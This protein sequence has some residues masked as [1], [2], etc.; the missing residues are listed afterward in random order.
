[1]PRP[2]ERIVSLCPSTSESVIALGAGST[3]VGI[4]RF[5]VHPAEQ[6]ERLTKVGGT[7]QPNVERIVALNP[8][9]VL[10]N[11]E[12]NRREDHAALRERGLRVE[13]SFPKGPQEIPAH[14]RWLG[15]LLGRQPAGEDWAG[16]IEAELARP[17][18]GPGFDYVY[19]VWRDPWMA[20]GPDTYIDR[21]LAW[22]GGRNLAGP[23]R[24]PTLEPGR[25]ADP[26]VVLLPD[27]PFP[28]AEKHRGEVQQTFPRSEPRFVSGD[29][30]C[31]HGVRT[32]R[33]LRLARTL[34]EERTRPG[35][36][37]APR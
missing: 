25:G 10:M 16:R 21:L 17:P 32:L 12:E 11:E 19:L 1:M 23:E 14:L 6:V 13:T 31:W 20:A 18:D 26:E 35:D 2:P 29:D 15:D 7:K 24:Y 37:R 33:G 5:C 22:A 4:T 34:A 3:L 36:G 28:F 27:E 30:L 9:L 8:D